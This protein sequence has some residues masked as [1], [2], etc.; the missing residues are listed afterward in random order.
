MK[1]TLETLYTPYTLDTYQTFNFERDEESIMQNENITD[2]DDI[3][4]T[5]DYEGY[6]KDLA[7]NLVVLLNDNILDDVILKIS[8]D[9]EVSSPKEYNF[10]TDKSWLDFD[11]DIKKLKAYIKK[12]QTDY[13]K[14]K[15]G[16]CDGFM[17]FGNENE[18]MLNYYLFTKSVK[19]Y[20][21]FEYLQDQ[22]ESVPAGEYIEYKVINKLNK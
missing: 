4:W 2:Y 18:T 3:D 7:T 14:N 13:D 11:I 9:N 1:I 16:S 10:T 21:N 20:D 5:Y 22:F 17:W 12:N 15:L 19:K 6:L 8:S